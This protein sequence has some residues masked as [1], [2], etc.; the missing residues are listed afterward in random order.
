MPYRVL[1]IL[2]FL[3]LFIVNTGLAGDWRVIP[4]K[5]FLGPKAKSG[6]V[7]LINND[8]APLNLQVTAMT[9]RQDESGQD[10][11]EETEDIIFFPRVMTVPAGKEQVLRAGIKIPATTIE[12]TYRL[13]I[14]EIPEATRTGSAAVTVAVRFGLPIFVAP[15]E[16]KIGAEITDAEIKGGVFNGSAVNNGNI[17]FLPSKV[18]L[19][20]KDSSGQELFIETLKPWYLLANMTR[21]YRYELKHEQCQNLTTLRFEISNNTHKLFKDIPVSGAQCSR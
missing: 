12:K 19:I 7:R 8:S 11:Y 13:F 14:E 17:H 4:I 1:T 2:S 6:S 5:M 16:E 21:P 10:I 18:S 3:L 9:W 20:G 15:L